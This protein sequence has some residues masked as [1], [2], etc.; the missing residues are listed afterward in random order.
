MWNAASCAHAGTG[1]D[2]HGERTHFSRAAQRHSLIYRCICSLACVMFAL[3]G[4][5]KLNSRKLHSPVLLTF[6]FLFQKQYS[7][8]SFS[9]VKARRRPLQQQHPPLP[10]RSFRNIQAAPCRRCRPLSLQTHLQGQRLRRQGGALLLV[11]LLL[12]AAE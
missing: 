12:Q 11:L 3:T 2:S 7:R 9:C 4:S 6:S 8:S 10:H 5:G 1:A